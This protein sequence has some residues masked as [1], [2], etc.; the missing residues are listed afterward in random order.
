MAAADGAEDDAWND[1][2]NDDEAAWL[3]TKGPWDNDACAFECA[4]AGAE[5]PSDPLSCRI[6]AELPS[7]PGSRKTVVDRRP[8]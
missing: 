1:A 4:E 8:R 5:P 6:E 7:W 2:W 3:S